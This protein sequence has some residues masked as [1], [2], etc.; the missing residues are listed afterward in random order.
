MVPGFNE[1]NANGVIHFDVLPANTITTKDSQ[2]VI[3]DLGQ[4]YLHVTPDEVKKGSDA[5]MASASCSSFYD[6]TVK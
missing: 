6:E 5:F 3:I 2:I 1:I 4:A